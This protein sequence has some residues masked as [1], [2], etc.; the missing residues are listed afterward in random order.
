MNKLNRTTPPQSH[1][2]GHIS[3]LKPVEHHLSNGVKIYAIDGGSEDVAKIDIIFN[4][5]L[6]YQSQRQLALMANLMLNEGTDKHSAHQIAE[7]YDFYGAYLNLSIDQHYGNISVV[8]LNRY[9]KEILE[10]TGE[11]ITSSNFPQNRFDTLIAKRKHKFQ[12]ENE[13]VKTLC[14]KKFSQVLFGEEHPYSNNNQYEDF[15]QLKRDDLYSF[16][17]THYTPENCRIII[18]GKIS[19]QTIALIEKY[20]GEKSWPSKEKVSAKSF[21]IKPLESRHYFIEKDDAVQSAIRVGRPMFNKTHPDYAGFQVL[22]TI[23]GGYFGSRLM[24][25]IREEKGYTYGIG[26]ALVSMEQAGY[27]FITSEVG[28][29]VCQP[30]LDEVYKE[31]ARLRNELVPPDE[32]EVVRNYMLGELLRDFDGPFSQSGSFREVIFY[33]LDY[34]HYD[35]VANT[36]RNITSQDIQALAQKY[37]QKDTLFEVVA[38]KKV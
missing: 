19:D 3:Y 29:E 6:W 7:E 26:S 33:G 35:S 1:P 28:N 32:L 34:S 31:I 8:T 38:G 11:I 2:I 17:K 30:A 25:N 36:I 24:T 23:L 5:G 4:A 14:L 13:K 12:I 18:S 20:L 22:N 21:K 9:L 27:F 37:L 16:Y 10:I 15:D